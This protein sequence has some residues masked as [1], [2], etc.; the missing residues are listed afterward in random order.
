MTL[1]VYM[2]IDVES[3]EALS[4]WTEPTDA[5]R[6][7]SEDPDSLVVTEVSLDPEE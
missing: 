2:V 5:D 1:T 4:A 7:A 6:R 3:G